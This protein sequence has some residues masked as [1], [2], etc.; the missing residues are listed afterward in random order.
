MRHPTYITLLF[1][2]SIFVGLLLSC[3]HLKD[4]LHTPPDLLK[5][6]PALT[7]TPYKPGDFLP[8]WKGNALAVFSDPGT[9]CQYLVS[10]QHY[11]SAIT[12]RMVYIDGAVTQMGCKQ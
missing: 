12:P 7:D 3:V 1:A 10:D 8:S 2:A 4:S 11:P 6:P 5:A 9:G